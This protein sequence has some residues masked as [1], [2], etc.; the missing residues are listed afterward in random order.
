M[1]PRR[2]L[3]P[4]AVINAVV[5]VGIF[6]WFFSNAVFMLGSKAAPTFSFVDT[7]PP[8]RTAPPVVKSPEAPAPHVA[9]EVDRRPARPDQ[10]PNPAT[11]P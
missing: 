4:A 8:P 10:S 3:R 6:I 5:L 11:L 7:K 2:R 1:E 9:P